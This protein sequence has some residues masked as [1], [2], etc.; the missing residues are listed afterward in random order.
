M[1]DRLYRVLF[2]VG[3]IALAIFAVSL[4]Q[5]ILV[6]FAAAFAIAYLLGPAVDRLESLGVRRGLASL[7]LLIAFLLALGFVLVLIVPL[8]Q[9]QFVRLLER[10]PDLVSGAQQQ[11]GNLMQL[12]RRHLPAAEAAKVRDV[13]SQ[14]IGDVVAGS[15]AC[16]RAWSPAALRF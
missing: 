2:W 13:V 14:E 11:F 8:V 6:P 9:G 10:F 1:S 7:V 3:I 12:L 16:Y 4:L 15:P 5:G